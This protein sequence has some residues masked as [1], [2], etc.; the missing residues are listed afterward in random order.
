ME[1]KS[2]KKQNLVQLPDE[3]I[4]PDCEGKGYI[5]YDC[6]EWEYCELCDQKGYICLALVKNWIKYHTVIRISCDYPKRSG[7]QL[8]LI[9]DSGYLNYKDDFEH[10]RSTGEER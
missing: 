2:N 3:L 5:D 1:N 9:K 8:N 7:L 10:W 6:G 4:C